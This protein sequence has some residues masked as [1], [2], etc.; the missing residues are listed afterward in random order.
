MGVGVYYR[1][2]SARIKVGTAVTSQEKNLTELFTHTTCRGG[3][4]MVFCGG[5]IMTVD[6]PGLA[7]HRSWD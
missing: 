4:F 7:I 5:Y 3:M 2:F 1:L 6:A